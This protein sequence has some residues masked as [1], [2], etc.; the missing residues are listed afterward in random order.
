MPARIGIYRGMTDT[1]F[2]CDAGVVLIGGGV[3]D[4]ADLAIARALAPALVAADGGGDRALALGAVPER[5]IGDLDSLSETARA[6]LG[7]RVIRVAEQ[8]ST[9]FGK[10]LSHVAAPFYICLGFAGLRLDHTLAAL[11]ELA[12][13]PRQ[14]ALLIAE[15]EVVFR[16]PDALDLNLP[17]GER[18]SL[19]PFGPVR[20]R[21]T[22]LRWPLDGID[23]AP[24]G[25]VGT[26]NEVS[27]PTV[28]I[29]V[30]TGD[31]LLLLPKRYL[32]LALRAVT[33][34]R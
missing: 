22:G 31:A 25:R 26:S 15:D 10:C 4:P 12:R 32:P 17:V 29:H 7:A 11:S 27:G 33:R 5:V 16:L 3:V 9:D 28:S 14:P 23:F 21:S 20:A 6:R 18:V 34:S 13:R 24:A 1:F 19:F 2:T 8:E 30:E